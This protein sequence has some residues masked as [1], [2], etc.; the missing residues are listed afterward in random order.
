MTG[1]VVEVNAETDFVA[2]NDK[3]Q[4]AAKAIAA[5]AL[6]AKGDLEKI[7]ASSGAGLEG[8]AGRGG[9]RP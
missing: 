7:K 1:A 8:S 6:P 4:D 2:R 5:L 3:F 9:H